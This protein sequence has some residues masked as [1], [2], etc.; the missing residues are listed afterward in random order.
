[1]AIA[2]IER[3]IIKAKIMPII[4]FSFNL[5]PPC[6][7]CLYGKYK[8]GESAY[9][10]FGILSMINQKLL[11]TINQFNF[12]LSKFSCQD[13]YQKWVNTKSS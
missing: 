5:T 11:Y 7:I 1:M 2:A 3:E 9:Y 6:F 10:S 12:I 4:T 8:S 13:F